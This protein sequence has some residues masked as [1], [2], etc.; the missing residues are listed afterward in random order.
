MIV[1]FEVGEIDKKIEDMDAKLR[2]MFPQLVGW[3]Y[4]HEDGVLMLEF[5]DD[6]SFI[7]RVKSSMEKVNQRAKF[8]EVL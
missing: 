8:K 3:V 5:L 6:T 7:E 2:K 4:R 1:V